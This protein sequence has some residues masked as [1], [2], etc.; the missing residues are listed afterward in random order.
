[1]NQRFLSPALPLCL[2]LALLLPAPGGARAADAPERLEVARRVA[3]NPGLGP[4]PAEVDR[5]TP[6]ATWRTFIDLSRKGQFAAAAHCLDLTEIPDEQQMET[7]VRTAERLYRVLRAV[8][9]RRDTV[10]VDTPEGPLLEDQPTNFVVA[11]RFDRRG[12]QGEIW[13]RRTVDTTTGEVVWLFTRRTVSDTALWYRVLVR[14]ESLQSGEL[15]AGLGPVPPG[16]VRETPRDTVQG[17]LEA[18]RSSEFRKAAFYLDLGATPPEQQPEVGPLLARRLVLVLARTLWINPEELSNDPGGRPEVGLPDDDELIGTVP[19]RGGEARIL[20]HRHFLEG[21]ESAW[22][23]HRA[24]VAAIDTLYAE[25]GFGWLGDHLPTWFFTRSFLGVQLW[26]WTG[27]V[28]LVLLAW[29]VSRVVTPLLMGTLR[30]GAR[31]TAVE[32][33]DELVAALDGPARLGVMAL[34]LWATVPLLGISGK[35]GDNLAV[36]WK[37]LAIV[38]LGWVL[39]RWVDIM[40]AVLRYSSMAR[41]NDMA[42]NFIPIFGRILKVFVWGVCAIVALDSLGIQVMGLVAG[43]G[44]GGVAVAFAAQKTIENLFGSITIA[45]NRPFEIGSFIKIGSLTGSVEEVGLLST[46]LRT[47][48]R[49]LVT[50]PNGTLLS[51]RVENYSARDRFKYEI[52]VG[53]LYDSTPAQVEYVVDGIK[54]MLLAHPKVH[55]DGVRVRFARFGDSALEVDVLTW[56]LAADYH[57]STALAEELN[58]EILRIV[59]ESGTGFAFPSQT[60]YLGTDAGIDEEKARKVEEEVADRR[61]RGDLW[62]PEPP[63]EA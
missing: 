14:G 57:E 51:E 4:V 58:F 62:I 34:V 25:H 52:T 6:A 47:M 42:R 37:L 59:S 54:K 56:V 50:I 61:K 45:A 12:I 29:V 20:L 44:I 11:L 23:F 53:L 17:F 24:T 3:I 7:G 2:G 39:T 48:A 38:F 41:R 49:T 13:L 55:H 36:A 31:R 16:V 5:S 21:G 8:G 15:N 30:R 46:R 27:F 1:M 63:A 22:V 28:L 32:W 18:C 10:D 40:A 19:L 33:D 9:A 26:Q 60:V 43:L 35:A